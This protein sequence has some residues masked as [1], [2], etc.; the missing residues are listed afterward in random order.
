MKNWCQRG[1]INI[2]FLL[3]DFFFYKRRV[4]AVKPFWSCSLIPFSCSL[5]LPLTMLQ[6]L[7]SLCDSHCHSTPHGMTSPSCLPHSTL[8]LH[9][10]SHVLDSLSLRLVGSLA[11]SLFFSRCILNIFI[12]LWNYLLWIYLDF[13]WARW[14]APCACQYGWNRIRETLWLFL[15]LM[16]YVW[17]I[18]S[19]TPTLFISCYN[20]LWHG[21]QWLELCLKGWIY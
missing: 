12:C 7:F 1:Q 19:L 10:C 8:A 21:S 17:I 15:V 11:I 5:T 13:G 4:L 2:N 18:L 6:I 20:T 16:L 3:L 14:W 9:N